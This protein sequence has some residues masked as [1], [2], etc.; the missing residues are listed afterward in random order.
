MKTQV[1]FRHFNGQHPQLQQSAE[2]IAAGFSKYH[3]GIT[4]VNIDFI[5][6]TEKQ[7][8]ITVILQGNMLNAT[9]SSDDLHTSLKGASDRMLKQIQKIK[10]KRE[11]SHTKKNNKDFVIED[12]EDV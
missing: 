12:D 6:D 9:H 4:S 3:N 5:N 8:N 11:D 7:V 2:N 1:T 10:E